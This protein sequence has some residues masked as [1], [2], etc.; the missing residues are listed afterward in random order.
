MA[1]MGPSRPWPYHCAK[2]I[3][4]LPVLDVQAVLMR[5]KLT[6]EHCSFVHI[7]GLSS[8]V[9]NFICV[10]CVQHYSCSVHRH[11]CQLPGSGRNNKHTSYLRLARVCQKVPNSISTAVMMVLRVHMLANQWSGACSSHFGSPSCSGLAHSTLS[12]VDELSPTPAV[13]HGH[14][15]SWH[16]LQC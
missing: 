15:P 8:G 7:A 11:C 5:C 13:I 4:A 16:V 12:A 14:G 9:V 10:Q 3:V 1:C 2:D 6:F